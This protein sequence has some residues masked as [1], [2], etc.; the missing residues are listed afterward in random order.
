M[1]ASF[2]D[3]VRR[4]TEKENYDLLVGFF[5]KNIT[6]TSAWMLIISITNNVQQMI[7]SNNDANEIAKILCS[8]F[9]IRA[10]EIQYCRTFS[11]A[12]SLQEASNASSVIK[13]P[14]KKDWHKTNN[15]RLIHEL[16]TAVQ[17]KTIEYRQALDLVIKLLENYPDTD[18]HLQG[19][20]RYP[21]SY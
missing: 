7:F 17:E 19:K 16:R 6:Q 13:F 12:P 14:F 11:S 2:V 20:S 1:I 9:G 21:G 15:E 4:K 10:C 18:K 3:Q 8:E 5:C